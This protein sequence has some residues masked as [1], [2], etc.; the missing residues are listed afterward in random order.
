MSSTMLQL[1][2]Q[3]AKEMGLAAPT[4]V[5]SN[6][7]ADVVQMLALLNAAGSEITRDFDWQK[8]V[9]AHFFTG[10]F[11]SYT[12]DTTDGVAQIVNMSSVQSLSSAFQVTGNGINQDTSIDGVSGSSVNLDQPATA[13]A[14]AQTFSFGK[15]EYDLPS[16]YECLLN[17]TEW[18]K[19]KHWR[20]LGPETAQQWQWLKSGY[21]STGPRVRFRLLGGYFQI[22]PQPSTNDVMGFE[23]RSNS[24]VYD[25]N[26]G[27]YEQSFTT[28]D[29]TCL[30]SDRLMVL[31]L[32]KK[33]F[34]IKG[35]DV[36]A[37]TR[38]YDRAMEQEK[39]HDQ[40]AATLSMAPLPAD[41]L[42]QQ[43]NIPDSGYGT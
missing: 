17:D 27:G 15:V 26:T 20:M 21:I 29:Q 1:V 36:T 31:A 24:W 14:S 41:I 7:A 10:E 38:D 23:Y 39:A 30:F 11:Y 13:T 3:A 43:S 34:E 16:D 2:Q 35:F 19:S 9:K 4:A 42:I 37:L 28:D 18:D 6:Q 32:K 5:A 40:G 8:L 33:Y 25:T 22:W 12:G